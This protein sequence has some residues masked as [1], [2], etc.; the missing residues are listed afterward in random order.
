MF[1]CM[2]IGVSSAV[3]AE[4]ML[5][6]TCTC[7]P[8]HV[9]TATLLSGLREMARVPISVPKTSAAPLRSCAEGRTS[10]APRPASARPRASRHFDDGV[11]SSARVPVIGARSAGEAHLGRRAAAPDLDPQFLLLLGPTRCAR[12]AC[13]AAH[14]SLS[15]SVIVPSAL[16]SRTRRV[17][18]RAALSPETPRVFVAAAAAAAAAAAR[19]PARSPH[20][21]GAPPTASLR[22]RPPHLGELVHGAV[23]LLLPRVRVGGRRGA[24]HLANDDD[25]LLLLLVSASE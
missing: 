9:K 2:R 23:I 25:H 5:P 11:R 16:V 17:G 13:R 14:A 19:P 24:A 4:S 3:Y 22:R 20:P 6:V 8:Y 7:A 10:A 1:S 18:P 21:R 12:C 15:V